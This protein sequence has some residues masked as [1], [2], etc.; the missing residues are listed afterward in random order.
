MADIASYHRHTV[1]CRVDAIRGVEVE[2]CTKSSL[3]VNPLDD[4]LMKTKGLLRA[5]SERLKAESV[6][7]AT[8]QEPLCQLP[9]IENSE[10]VALSRG[11]QLCRVERQ[12][13]WSGDDVIS[14]PPQQSCETVA[15]V[16]SD[17]FFG[18]GNSAGKVVLDSPLVM[19]SLDDVISFASMDNSAMSTSHADAVHFLG[20]SD[21]KSSGGVS[22]E[23]LDASP[24]AAGSNELAVSCCVCSEALVGSSGGRW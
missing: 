11:G 15:F 3:R 20:A 7:N 8:K 10:P 23:S 4:E 16:K 5:P 13:D 6:P 17:M 19:P 14:P 22:S 12:S 1:C 21:Q 24:C 9:V 18:G 2:R